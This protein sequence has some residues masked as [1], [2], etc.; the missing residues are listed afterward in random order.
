MTGF[1]LDTSGMVTRPGAPVAALND[2]ASQCRLCGRDNTGHEGEPCAEEC[3]SRAW[4][5]DDL[6]AFTQGYIEALFFTEEES[7]AGEDGGDAP[8]SQSAV[9]G[10]GDLAPEALARI[11]ADC[12]AFTASPAYVAAKAAW[13]DTTADESRLA[14]FP[15]D[16]ETRAGHDFWLTRNGHGAGFWDG[17]WPEPHASALN[18]AAKAFGEAETYLGDDGKV[19]LT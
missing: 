3:P 18:D 16:E 10:F 19:Y 13:D 2:A 7:L 9:K 15:M 6:D 12:A 17:D 14:G 4:M 1:K 11:I 8:Y 5:W